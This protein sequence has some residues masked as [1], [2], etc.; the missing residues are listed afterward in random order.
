MPDLISRDA[1]HLQGL[2]RFYTGT[3]CKHGHDCERYTSTNGCV[4]CVTR[5]VTGKPTLPAKLRN[6]EHV[7][8]PTAPFIFSGQALVPAEMDAAMRL[9]QG[10]GWHLAAMKLIRENAELR[11]KYLK[12]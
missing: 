1:A 11:E 8:Y 6:H 3:P 12:M 9:M 10:E 4:Q 2:T 7:R 5:K